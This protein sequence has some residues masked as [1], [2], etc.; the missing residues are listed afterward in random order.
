[1]TWRLA[2][3]LDTSLSGPGREPLPS[4]KGHNFVDD[5]KICY[6]YEIFNIFF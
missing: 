5:E 4:G 1:M 2:E 6:D 3:V